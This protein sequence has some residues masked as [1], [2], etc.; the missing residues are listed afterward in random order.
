MRKPMILTAAASLSLAAAVAS[1]VMAQGLG[2]GVGVGAQVTTPVANVG[3]GTNATTG[4]Q[5]ELPTAAVNAR[6][7]AQGAV[8]ADATGVANSSVHSVLHGTTDTMTQATGTAK[9]VGMTVLDASGKSVG[10]VTKV[11]T[12]AK[13]DIT[14]VLVKSG[15]ATKRIDP[16]K[17][18]VTGE[19][20]LTVSK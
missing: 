9:M 10:K 3:V 2:V 14:T 16:A 8:N 7:N 5:V 20:E 19:T 12:N 15:K 11:A 6:T 4:A 1:P 17:L 18:S 13:G